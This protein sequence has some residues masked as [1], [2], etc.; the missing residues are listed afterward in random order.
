V[1]HALSYHFIIYRFCLLFKAALI[2]IS[3]A[4]RIFD[5]I[6]WKKQSRKANYYGD[7]NCKDEFSSHDV[8]F[9]L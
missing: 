7:G 6:R 2:H 3:F 1:G 4:G 9:V 5:R 8:G